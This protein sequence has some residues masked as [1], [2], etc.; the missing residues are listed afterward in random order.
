[1]LALV[2]LLVWKWQAARPR[3]ERPPQTA[4]PSKGVDP[5]GTP[6]HACS[7]CGLHVPQPEAV[8]GAQAWY[9]CEAHRRRAEA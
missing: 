1:M 4:V 9:C 7:F 6:M 8:R 3:R 5:A 2:A